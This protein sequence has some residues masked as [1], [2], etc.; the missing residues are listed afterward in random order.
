MDELPQGFLSLFLLLLAFIYS[1]PRVELQLAIQVAELPWEND[2][3]PQQGPTCTQAA[4]IDFAVFRTYQHN[5]QFLQSHHPSFMSPP[6]AA[7]Q[8][9]AQGL[10]EIFQPQA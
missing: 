4:A 7:A 2:K 1:A 5:C 9:L 6:C 3:P 10:P 8:K